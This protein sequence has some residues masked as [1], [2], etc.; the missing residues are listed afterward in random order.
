MRISNYLHALYAVKASLHDGIN[1]GDAEV[2]DILTTM[3][4]LLKDL[5][6]IGAR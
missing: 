5:E 2:L 6:E 3:C 4:G 1:G